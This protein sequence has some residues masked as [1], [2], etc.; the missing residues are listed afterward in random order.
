MKIQLISDGSIPVPP[1]GWGAL[2]RV[3]WNYKIHLEKLGHDVFVSNHIE[4]HKVLEDYRKFKPDVI[5]NHIGKHWYPFSLM[6]SSKKFF[7]NHGSGVR[8]IP[9]NDQFWK[10]ICPLLKDSL[11]LALT[12]FEVERFA[13]NGVKAIVHPNGIDSEHITFQDKP[14]LGSIYLGKI[15]PLKRQ[16]LLQKSGLEVVFIGDKG[17]PNFNYE[18]ERYLGAWDYE[19]VQ[20]DL[21]KY[22]N[23]VLLSIDEL[24][25]LVCLEAMSA[26]LGLVVSKPAAQ[27][28]DASKPWITIIDEEQIT[29]I[30]FV[31]HQIK[32][33]AITSLSMRTEIREY[34]KEFD[35]SNIVEKYIDIIA[36]DWNDKVFDL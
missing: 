18:D 10:Q 22:T 20:S 6:S 34:A 9:G 16:A 1:I 30:D 27:S 19:T 12:D 2:E 7:T 23:L 36:G 5:H 4:D 14:E 24:Q 28:L 33:N 13:A 8:T 31:N 21:T 32:Q 15:L 29:D 35:W 17:D 25:P 11:C 26:G 3:V